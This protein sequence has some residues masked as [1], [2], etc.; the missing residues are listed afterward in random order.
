MA[1]GV[2]G[3]AR[4]P[5]ARARLVAARAQ[6]WTGR[7]GPPRSALAASHLSDEL[8]ALATDVEGRQ[9][10]RL[11][12]LHLENAHR[13]RTEAMRLDVEL[14]LAELVPTPTVDAEHLGL[15]DECVL[16]RRAGVRITTTAYD[17]AIQLPQSQRTLVIVSREV[18]LGLHRAVLLGVGLNE[19]LGQRVRRLLIVEVVVG[20]E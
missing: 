3:I 4:A 11:G 16:Q 1:S 10:L 14:H 19:D 5:W 9:H 8:E 18:V 6:R 12:A 17:T 2:P 7:V 13:P 15:G 20:D